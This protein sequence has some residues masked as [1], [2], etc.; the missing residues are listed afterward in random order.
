MLRRLSIASL[1]ITCFSCG[2]SSSSSVNKPDGSGSS[3]PIDASDDRSLSSLDT[4]NPEAA[5]GIGEVDTPVVP[6]WDAAPSDARAVDQGRAEAGS[7]AE[8]PVDWTTFLSRHDLVWNRLA[9]YWY[10]APFVGNGMLGTLMR[11]M[12][13]NTIR[14]DI[15]RTDVQDHQELGGIGGSGRLPVGH[16]DLKT[17]GKITSAKLRLDLWNAELTGTVTTDGGGLTLRA[18]AHASDMLIVVE[19]TGTG[20]EADDTF[21]F[22]A[23]PAVNPRY[24]VAP[25]PGYKV[26]PAATTVTRNGINLVI[27]PVLKSGET[28]TAWRVRQDA[29]SK[30][31]FLTVQHSYPGTEA[32]ADA[33]KA[34]SAVATTSV[35]NLASTHRDWWHKYYPASFLSLTDAKLESF[36]WIQMYKYASG[37][38]SDRPVLDLMGPWFEPTRWPGLWWD[39]NVQLTYWA[40][41]A[42]NHL[43][44]GA[45]LPNALFRNQANLI[46]NVPAE[47]QNDSAALSA[48]SGQEMRIDVKPP[49][50]GGLVG[51]FLWALHD[52][53][54]NYRHSMDDRMLR[55]QLFPLLKRGVT[56][57]VR[58]LNTGT[59]GKLHIPSTESPEYGSAPDTNYDLALLR[60]GLK[61]LLAANTRLGLADAQATTWQK[62][63]D[64]LVDYPTD[65]LDG[66]LIGQGLALTKSHGT[67]SH[68]LAA[69]PLHLL[70]PENVKDKTLI[71]NTFKHWLSLTQAFFGYSHTGAASIYATLGDGE[72]ALRFLTTFMNR[73]VQAST[74]YRETGDLPCIESPLSAVQVMFDMLLQSWGDVI[75]VFPATPD[76][77]SDISFE[78][79]RTE[80]AFLVSAQRRAGKTQWVRISSQAGEACR[81]RA[82][83]RG[84]PKITGPAGMTAETLADGSLKLGLKKGETA[85]LVAADF[86]GPLTTLTVSHPASSAN[87]YGLR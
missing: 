25:W 66:L 54:L 3:T 40:T 9:K 7:F 21:N 8:G 36:Y 51:D 20:S 83:F 26:N 85:E 86:S 28:A 35:P 63:L 70:D 18:F 49:G 60:W 47:Y 39:L 10:D 34:I 57:Y 41:N 16:V 68:M 31:L 69:Y 84:T 64:Q 38:R 50:A 59:D 82:S 12:D 61:T 52:C 53:W 71:L 1:L 4:L 2:G 15:G 80:G 81:V 30:T 24:S 44:I 62:T 17:K 58:T 33:E 55:E 77:W 79:L 72:Q 5:G 75:R 65:R 29:T 78:N 23:E 74:M 13:S 67:Y 14:F 43:D 27:Q 73:Y 42:S 48:N 37:T 46:A 76:A 87:P 19:L 32:D 6:S 11:Q 22:V 56:Y 45:S